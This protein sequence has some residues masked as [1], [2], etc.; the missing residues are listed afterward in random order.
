MGATIAGMV[1]SPLAL[2]ALMELATTGKTLFG[3]PKLAPSSPLVIAALR[4][5]ARAWSTEKQVQEILEQA[6]RSK[7][8]QLRAAVSRGRSAPSPPDEVDS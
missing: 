3:R 6:S 2:N 5:L 7:D 8:P 1:Q 4:A